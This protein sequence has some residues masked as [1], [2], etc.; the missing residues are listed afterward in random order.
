MG[1]NMLTPDGHSAKKIEKVMLLS[2]WANALKE[3]LEVHPSGSKMILAGL[4]RPTYPINQHTINSYLFYWRRL[5]ELSRQWHLNP[6]SIAD[7]VAIDYGDPRGDKKPRQLMAKM[8]T[9][10]YES[11]IDSE[12]ILFTVGGIGF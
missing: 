5:E 7:S 8:M 6:D 3:E 9:Q 10:W 12:H 11:N 2:L 4:G 1:L